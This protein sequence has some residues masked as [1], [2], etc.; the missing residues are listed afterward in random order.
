MWT[1]YLLEAW[2]IGIPLWFV[3]LTISA[4]RVWDEGNIEIFAWGLPGLV[5]TLLIAAIF[6]PITMLISLYLQFDDWRANRA[7]R[8]FAADMKAHADK[9]IEPLPA[10]PDAV[11]RPLPPINPLPYHPRTCGKCGAEISPFDDA[12]PCDPFDPWEERY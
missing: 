5:A 10:N 8:K 2:C 4:K 12:C 7:V 11:V 9:S 1:T 6:W 3:V